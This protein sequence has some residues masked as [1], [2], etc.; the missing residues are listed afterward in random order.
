M[1]SKKSSGLS[2]AIHSNPYFSKI[3]EEIETKKCEA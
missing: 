3:A 1:S 2:S